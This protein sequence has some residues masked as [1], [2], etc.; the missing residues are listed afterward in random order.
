MIS[1]EEHDLHD[2]GMAWHV[3]TTS[4]VFSAVFY[5]VRFC[6][7]VSFTEPTT[8]VLFSHITVRDARHSM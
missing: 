1:S 7:T 4:V 8:L 5:V 2:L 3:Q 6:V